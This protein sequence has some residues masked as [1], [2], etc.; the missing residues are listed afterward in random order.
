MYRSTASG[1]SSPSLRAGRA[2][3][4]DVGGRDVYG[5][6][7]HHEKGAGRPFVKRGR[8]LAPARLRPAGGFLSAR[9]AGAVSPGH[10][11][12]GVIGKLP[13]APPG[14]EHLELIGADQQAKRA[15]SGLR[16]EGGEGV[17][18][19]TEPLAGELAV[20]H[21]QSRKPPHRCGQHG[22]PLV[23]G[24]PRRGPV[25]RN[26]GRNQRHRIQSDLPT[27][28]L[29]EPQVAVVDGVEGAAQDTERSRSARGLTLPRG[30]IRA[31]GRGFPARSGQPPGPVGRSSS[32]RPLGPRSAAELESGAFRRPA[33]RSATR[34]RASVPGPRPRMAGRIS[35]ADVTVAENDE[36]L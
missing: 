9:P 34:L 16:A 22:Q 36:L 29:R 11:Q 2:P 30:A 4:P 35:L 31:L 3:C 32:A 14:V 23:A 26:A 18:G 12:M 28:F 8:V 13:P 6:K 20:V 25:H 1:T 21:I 17:D 7:V 15:L 33:Q 10:H 24:R 27:S 5:R 19:P